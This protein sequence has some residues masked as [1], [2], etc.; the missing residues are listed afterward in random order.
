MRPENIQHAFAVPKVR[1]GGT[2]GFPCSPSLA[3]DIR[4]GA[5]LTPE[6]LALP[7]CGEGARAVCV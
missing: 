5:C 1:N 2:M 3:R 6:V 7:D 4:S